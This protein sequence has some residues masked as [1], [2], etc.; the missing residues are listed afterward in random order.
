TNYQSFLLTAILMYLY[1]IFVFIFLS[2]FATL[3]L[4]VRH[5]NV[6]YLPKNHLILEGVGV[7][8]PGLMRI[9]CN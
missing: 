9:W 2:S 1:H 7:L 8:V 5:E 4:G 3:R 6:V